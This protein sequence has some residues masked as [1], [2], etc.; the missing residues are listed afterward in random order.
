[1]KKENHVLETDTE[2]LPEEDQKKE[3]PLFH[4]FHVRSAPLPTPEEMRGYKSI[5]K[6]FPGRI[7]K[8]AEKEQNFRHISTYTGMAVFPVLVIAGFGI[9]AYVAVKGHEIAA[10]VIAGAVGYIVYVFKTN[11]PKPPKETTKEE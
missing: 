1:M 11:N 4:K 10:S 5:D 6:S 2:V 9:S 8:M 3:A 7:I